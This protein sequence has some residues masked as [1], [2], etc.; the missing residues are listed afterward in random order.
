[1]GVITIEE[2]KGT[3]TTRMGKSEPTQ[4]VLIVRNLN[5]GE[6]FHFD[7]AWLDD[8]EGTKGKNDAEV[9]KK[10]SYL[11]GR[12]TD[13]AK[14][15]KRNVSTKQVIDPQNQEPNGFQVARFAAVEDEGDE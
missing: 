6:G 12:I 1:M 2:Y 5:P 4:S 14:R 9:S 3:P 11:A 13:D 10:C 8:N 7:R 15:L